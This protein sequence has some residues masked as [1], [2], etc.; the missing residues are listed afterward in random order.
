MEHNRNSED[1]Y[2]LAAHSGGDTAAPLA[3]NAAD[4]ADA[5]R[6]TVELTGVGVC[7]ID[8]AGRFLYVNPALCRLTR[9]STEELLGLTLQDVLQPEDF[10]ETMDDFRSLITGEVSACRMERRYLR[11]DGSSWWADINATLRRAPSG[12]PQ[13]VIAILDDISERKQLEAQLRTANQQLAQ[14]VQESQQQAHDL[15]ATFEAIVDLVIVFDKAGGIR[16][17][18][19]AVRDFMSPQP[20]LEAGR[21]SVGLVDAQGQPLPREQLTSSRVLRG[22]TLTGSHGVDTLAHTQA[23]REVFFNISGAPVYDSNEHIAG[24]VIVMRDMTER[25]KLERHTQ[26]ALQALLQM[27]EAL[28]APIPSPALMS[29]PGDGAAAL[30][31]LNPVTQ[32]L[33]ELAGRVLRCQR[34]GI[35]A[36][37]ADHDIM[38]PVALTGMPPKQVAAWCAGLE[39]QSITEFIGADSVRKLMAGEAVWI[40]LERQ[41]IRDVAHGR[42]VALAVP[43]RLGDQL[44]GAMALGHK[45]EPHTYTEDELALAAAVGQLAALVI[46]RERLLQEREKE[47]ANMLALQATNRRMEEFLGIASHEL[48][49]PLA[50]LLGNLQLLQR[51]LARTPPSETNPR[52]LAN[53]LHM[54][55]TLLEQMHRQGKRLSRIVGDMVNTIR[56]QSGKLEFHPQ[57]YDLRTIVQEAVDEQRLAEPERNIDL[58]LP[59]DTPVPVVA[60]PDRIGQVVTNYLTN[61]LKYSREDQPIEVRL[62]V[63]DHTARVSVRDHG[64]GLPPEEQQQIWELF[65]RV[66]S[67]QVQSGSGIGLGLGLHICKTIIERHSGQVGVES[68][69]G[70]G[71][72]FWFTLPLDAPSQVSP[73]TPATTQ[74]SSA[75]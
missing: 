43:L 34:V 24:G 56:D 50:S 11:Q 23:G 30:P 25:R 13:Y 51:R 17:V 53:Q 21:Q 20:T 54:V 44:V 46:E 27:A 63:E 1:A 7:H 10:A 2:H 68:T 5:F 70:Q 49:T 52:D 29:Q 61:A 4:S 72:S 33:A 47:R 59:G 19:K 32:R 58:A 48:R 3:Y 22:E 14:T 71:S 35:V 16:R 40:D 65:H 66:P 60:D 74:P 31:P 69:T 75:G 45:E 38:R 6:T 28:V 55:D 36:L 37:E 39:G 26:E 64:P 12:V 8:L 41:P 9:A 57:P 15:E 62:R 67:I 18:N 42:P 73:A